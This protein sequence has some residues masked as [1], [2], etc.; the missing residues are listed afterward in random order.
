MRILVS[1][2]T[3]TAGRYL[4][5]PNMGVLLTPRN[6]NRFDHLIENGYYWA[7]DNSAFSE[8]DEEAFCRLICKIARAGEY[9]CAWIAAPDVVG[10][11]KATLERWKFWGPAIRSCKL[12]PAFVC[13]DGCT[14]KEIPYEAP[15]VFLGG[16][17]E[18]KMSKEARACVKA[19]HRADQFV[20]M[21]RVNSLKR[22]KVA[23]LWGCDSVDGSSL[24]RFPKTYIPKFLWWLQEMERVGGRNAC[25]MNYPRWNRKNN[26]VEALAVDKVSREI[27]TAVKL[28]DVQEL[29]RQKAADRQRVLDA[30]P[31]GN[32]VYIGGS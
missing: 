18:W 10:D 23:Y 24:S 28:A 29:A 14:S 16:T 25:E 21:G 13:Q 26:L 15:C 8:W 30:W 3:K 6:R 31:C 12:A 9:C 20:H 5:H 4:D 7:V 2:G 22:L 32:M 27:G 17:T 1:G 19:A 11:H